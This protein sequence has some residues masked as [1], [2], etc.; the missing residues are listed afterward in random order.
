MTREQ[1]RQD[2]PLATYTLMYWKV[3]L[4]NLL[5]FLSLRMDSHAQLEIREFANAIGEIVKTWVPNVWE[6]F[7]DYR[8]EATTF[9]REEVAVLK[10]LLRGEGYVP[11]DLFHKDSRKEL[12]DDLAPGMSKRE[13]GAFLR[14]F[15]II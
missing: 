10:Q 7:V 8:L 13:R 2:L 5:H 9:S 12:F 3:D 4:H 11:E 6:A 14:A 1:A 15:D